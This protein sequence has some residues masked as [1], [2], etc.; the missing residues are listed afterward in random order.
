MTVQS[1]P[2]QPSKKGGFRPGSGRKP[3]SKNKSGRMFQRDQLA[4]AYTNALGGPDRVDPI[5]AADI[6]RAADLVLLAREMR[7]SVRQ[8]KIRL[9]ELTSLEGL[10]ARAVKALNLPPP[11]AASAPSTPTLADILAD[12]EGDR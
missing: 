11:G 12:H 7:Q 10:A 1:Q 3:G 6:I 2:S 4:A 5:V 9:A 8:G